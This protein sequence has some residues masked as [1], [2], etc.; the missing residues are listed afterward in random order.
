MTQYF[1]HNYSE[2]CRVGDK[3]LKRTDRPIE[4]VEGVEIAM[5]SVDGEEKTIYDILGLVPDPRYKVPPFAEVMSAAKKQREKL[6][7][8][9]SIEERIE[10]TARAL[11]LSRHQ[12]GQTRHTSIPPPAYF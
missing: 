5:Y 9:A 8:E 7:V 11:H 4:L 12:R 3:I 10:R 2:G 6:V 1:N